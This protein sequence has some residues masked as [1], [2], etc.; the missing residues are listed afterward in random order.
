MCSADVCT[1]AA[2]LGVLVE[3][4]CETDFVARG[5]KFKE[6]V[7]DLAMQARARFCKALLRVPRH[8]CMRKR[9]RKIGCSHACTLPPSW[10]MH[11]QIAASDVSMVAVEDAPAAELEHERAIE[12]QKEDILAKPE[13]IRRGPLHMPDLAMPHA[14]VAH[15]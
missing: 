7:N 8:A 4:N 2:R 14:G 9:L 3:V 11:A 6:L 15:Q 1:C 13:Q 10:S 5:D 12:M